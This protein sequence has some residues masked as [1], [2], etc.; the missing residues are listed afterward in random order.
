MTTSR[1]E[2][3]RSYVFQPQDR[4]FLDTNIWLS[5]YGPVAFQRKRSAI[6]SRALR[7]IRQAGSAI[8]I[9]VLVLSE[10]INAYSRM[11]FNQCTPRSSSFKAFRSSPDF[12]VI[13]LDIAKTAERIVKQCRRCETDF[14][15]ADI[16]SVLTEFGQGQSDFNDQMIAGICIPA[17]FKLI[18]DDRDFRT[19]GVDILTANDRLLGASRQSH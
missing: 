12:Q 10:F 8:F 15:T 19:A 1:I 18:T 14:M 11:E 17:N 7:D 9:D 4:L 2:D 5:I 16:E 6:Y 13:A 3:I